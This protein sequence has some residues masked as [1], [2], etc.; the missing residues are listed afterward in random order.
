VYK[1]YVK[2]PLDVTLAVAVIVLTLPL[3]LFA[4]LLIKVSSKGP[5]LFRQERTGIKGVNFKI[6]KFRTMTHN[7]DVR[8]ITKGNQLTTVGKYV[9]ALS[10]DEIPQLINIVKGE[11]SFIGPRPWIPEY[12]EFMT[13]E[14]RHRVD[15][16]P[17]MTGLAQVHGRNS[18]SIYKKIDYDLGYV[19]RIS[20]REDA[21]IVFL[22]IKAIVAKGSRE[23]EKHGIHTELS[24]LK[25]QR[26]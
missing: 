21:K 11:M 1:R 16:L 10:V 6:Y 5:V 22:T 2:R 18:L 26:G 25:D 20:P 17:G 3:T 14:Q 9:R 24:L 8:D 4:A 15:V 12:Y 13:K 7:N 19:N 23:I